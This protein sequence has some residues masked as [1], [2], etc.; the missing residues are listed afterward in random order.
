MILA[1]GPSIVSLN[2]N[3]PPPLSVP[4]H[5]LSDSEFG[6]WN[7]V[8]HGNVGIRRTLKKDDVVYCV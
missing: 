4:G 5:C 3:K 6:L 2:M 8:F 7:Q 1:L